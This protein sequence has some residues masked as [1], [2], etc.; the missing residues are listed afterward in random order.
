MMH[1]V[2]FLNPMPQPIFFFT[3][4]TGLLFYPSQKVDFL[5]YF[6]KNLIE[7]FYFFSYP[8]PPLV[9]A[10]YL[11]TIS[12]FFIEIGSFPSI[13]ITILKD[14]YYNANLN[15]STGRVDNVSMNQL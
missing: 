3:L 11:L 4:A 14:P 9:K 2:S 7:K 5:S 8:T 1:F 6:S 12:I 13:F 15:S 10:S